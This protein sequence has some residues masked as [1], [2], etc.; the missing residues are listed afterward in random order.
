[1]TNANFFNQTRSFSNRNV[2]AV[3]GHAGAGVLRDYER[4][5]A[6]G[7][8]GAESKREEVRKASFL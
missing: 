8:Q 7:L 2:S 1:M 3:S 5:R 6:A 4:E